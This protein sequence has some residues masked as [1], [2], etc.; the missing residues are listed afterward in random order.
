[1]GLAEDHGNTS[2]SSSVKSF[3]DT[4]DFHTT[5]TTRTDS[6]DIVHTDSLSNRNPTE[7]ERE[8]GQKQTAMRIP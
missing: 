6:V 4:V 3:E 1:M 5:Q 7:T 2:G 8:H